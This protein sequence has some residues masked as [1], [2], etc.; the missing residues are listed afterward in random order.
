MRLYLGADGPGAHHSSTTPSETTLWGTQAAI[1]QY[2]MVYFACQGNQYDKTA[3]ARQIVA[4]YA[5]GGGRIFASHYAYVWLYNVAAFSGTVTWLANKL[6]VFHDDPG[7]GVIDTSFARSNLLAQWLQA[8][9]A[10]TTQGQVPVG[11]LFH[12]F[13]GVVPPSLLWLRVNDTWAGNVP[14][15]FTFD[16]PPG[17]APAN[18]AGACSSA[19]STPSSTASP[20][21]A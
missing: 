5:N 15:H 14:M 8:I 7:T 1:D 21:R 18:R 12:D 19:I 17:A 6:T 20:P 10:T 2:D 4:N 11:G 9:G 13:T 3:T 16:A